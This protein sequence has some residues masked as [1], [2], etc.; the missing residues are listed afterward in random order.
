MPDR[1]DSGPAGESEAEND[2]RV[3]SSSALDR[4]EQKRLAV[5][6]RMHAEAVMQESESVL[7]C[8]KQDELIDEAAS[9]LFSA[10]EATWPG[11]EMPLLEEIRQGDWD[12]P[13]RNPTE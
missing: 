2:V 10:A 11:D 1:D 8:D 3:P 6:L 13:T 4:I 9:K 12:D 7:I 5:K